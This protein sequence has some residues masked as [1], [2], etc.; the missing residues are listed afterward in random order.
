MLVAN[1]DINAGELIQLNFIKSHGAKSTMF[2]DEKLE[3]FILNK[4]VFS[5]HEIKSGSL[6]EW[7]SIIVF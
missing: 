2:L 7:E 4:R 5:R 3:S 1:K 6:L